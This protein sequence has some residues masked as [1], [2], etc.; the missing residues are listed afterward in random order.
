MNDEFQALSLVPVF[1]L[2]AMLAIATLTDVTSH[3]I[4]NALLAPALSIALLVGTAAGGLAGL[5][6]ALS[7]LG[8][9][10]AL[11]LPLYAIGA[12]GAGDVKLLGVAGAFL[13]PHGAVVAGIMTFIAGAVFGLLWLGWRILRPSINYLL[14][15]WMNTQPPA[16]VHDE[17]TTTGPKVN[18]F[19]YAPAIAVGTTFAIWQQGW[20]TLSNLG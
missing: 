15:T 17:T 19:A 16:V 8:V 20:S 6:M 3:R 9:G 10:L 4:P 11:L 1:C 7:G 18:R 12:M 13:G 14:A 5:L 2:V